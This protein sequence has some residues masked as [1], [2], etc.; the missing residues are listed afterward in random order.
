M[1]FDKARD[2]AFRRLKTDRKKADLD[3]S[4]RID[5]QIRDPICARQVR[6][7]LSIYPLYDAVAMWMDKAHGLAYY[8]PED[9]ERVT[10]LLGLT[11]PSE[12]I[13]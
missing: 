5:R 10:R 3:L 12:H 8:F 6:V 11:G 2:E 7:D 13:T 1:D 9:M 4:I